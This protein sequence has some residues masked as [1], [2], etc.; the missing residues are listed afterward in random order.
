VDLDGDGCRDVAM[1]SCQAEE[2]AALLH[3]EGGKGC[4]LLRSPFVG[5]DLPDDFRELRPNVTSLAN[6]NG[7]LTSVDEQHGTG[8]VLLKVSFEGGVRGAILAD[9]DSDG[10]LEIIVETEGGRM[11]SLR[12]GG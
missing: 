4:R 6:L 2:S 3:K 1:I 11:R 12:G 7:D 10:L 9:A 5:H 8:I